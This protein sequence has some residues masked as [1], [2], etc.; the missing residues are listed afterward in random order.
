MTTS[1]ALPTALDN[2][3]EL[4]IAF[5]IKMTPL[6]EPDEEAMSASVDTVMPVGLPAVASPIVRPERVMVKDVF[7]A[8][9]IRAVVMTMVLPVMDDVAVMVV[10]DV[11]PAVLFAGLGVPAKN[12]G[13]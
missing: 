4:T 1:A 12:P 5:L 10:T 2:S 8:M 13:G 3:N 11:L 6:A 9:P 7:A